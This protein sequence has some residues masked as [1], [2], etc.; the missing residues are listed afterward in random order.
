VAQPTTAADASIANLDTPYLD[1]PTSPLAIAISRRPAARPASMNRAVEAA[2]AEAIQPQARP[3]TE[4]LAQP[5][6]QPELASAAP[7]PDTK[8]PEA[9]DEPEIASAAPSIPT[10]ASVAKQATLKNAIDLG[11]T[12]LI[13]VY[14]TPAKRYALVRTSSG[15]FKKVRKGDRVDGGKVVAITE[16][17]LRY[18]KGSRTMVLALPKT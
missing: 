5:D 17:E 15:G 4:P 12:N 18:Q 6:P 2:I 7:T 11:K 14:G 8:L 9:Q 3:A 1:G 10:R 13:G 16:N